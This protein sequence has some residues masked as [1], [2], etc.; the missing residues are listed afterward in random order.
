MEWRDQGRPQEAAGSRGDGLERIN[1]GKKLAFS[2]E[3]LSVSRGSWKCAAI[4]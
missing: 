2:I 4:A 1:P 3:E